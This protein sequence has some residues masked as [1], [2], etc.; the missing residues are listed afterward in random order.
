MELYG[1]QTSAIQTQSDRR[2]NKPRQL[3]EGEVLN[4]EDWS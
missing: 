2:F 1:V 3:K 4:K